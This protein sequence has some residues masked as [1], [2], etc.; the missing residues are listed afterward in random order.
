DSGFKLTGF[1]DADYAGCKDT[2][3]STFEFLIIGGADNSPLIFK[4]SMYDSWKSRMKLYIDNQE[5]KRMI[6][7]SVQNGLLIWP[8]VVEEDGTTRTKRYEELLV[9]EKLQADCDLKVVNIALQG[10]P[11]V[12]NS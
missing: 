12:L 3:K 5:N 2:F 8:N 11:R 6:L 9:V 7:N 4:K 1:S 10:L